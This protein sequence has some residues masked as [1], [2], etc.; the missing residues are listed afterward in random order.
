M[1]VKHPPRNPVL[2]VILDGFGISSNETNTI[3][4]AH[5]PVL[6]RYFGTFPNTLLAASGTAVAL[7]EGQMGNSEVGHLTLGAGTTVAQHLVNIDSAIKDGSF[8][9]NKTLMDAITRAGEKKRPIHLI[10]LVSDGGVHSHNNHLYALLELCR[11]HN[12][13]PLLHM[14]TDGRDTA[15]R[16]VKNHIEELSSALGRANGDIATVMGRYYAMD[17]DQRWQRTKA[18]WQAIALNQAHTEKSL[19]DAIS[20]AYDRGESDEF[21]S[22]VVLP[23]AKPVTADDEIIFFNYRKDRIKQLTKAF[24]A[25][26]FAYFSR[27]QYTPASIT[28]MTNYIADLRLPFAFE[29]PK[30]KT[31]LAATISKAGLSQ[32]HCA[33]TEKYA[34]VTY[35]FNGGYN[36]CHHNEEWCIVPSPKVATYDLAPA[37]SAAKVTERVIQAIERQSAFIVVN[38]ANGD[39]V[40]HT[41][42]KSAV[43]EAI[44]TLDHEV[45][46]L[47]DIAALANYSI[48]VTAD[49][50]NCEQLIDQDTGRPHTQHTNNPVPCLIIDQEP[51]KLKSNGSL[52]DVAPTVLQLMGLEIPA[53]MTGESLLIKESEEIP[54]FIPERLRPQT[55]TSK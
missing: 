17:R 55:V 2:L 52:K 32:F 14:I 45:G 29:Q 13:R 3:A 37:M 48:V 18:A 19:Q 22:P 6:D 20:N 9:S 46:R 44:E 47:L 51:W 1:N 40:G 7:P 28:C 43:I 34:H 38:F 12:V 53:E 54:L 23:A 31:T 50:G 8:F 11:R 27:H 5:T 10:G 41:A 4:D 30:P 39:M 42:V 24:A 26:H 21:I 35:F 16:S 33:E 25:D 49:H 15:P 36:R